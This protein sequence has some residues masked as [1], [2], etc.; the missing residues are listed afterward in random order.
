MKLSIIIVNWNNQDYIQKCL[1]SIHK[2]IT[3]SEYEIIV[4][5]NNS[6]DGSATII[7]ETYPKVIMLQNSVN[8]GFSKANNQGIGIAKGEHVLFLNSDTELIDNSIDKMIEFM[9]S[10][11]KIGTVSGKCLYPDGRIQWSIGKFPSP[12]MFLRSCILDPYIKH[13][14]LKILCSYK[15][16]KITITADA[17]QEQDYP[18][19]A[20]FM[21]KRNILK[22]IEGFDENLFLYAEDMD[23]GYRIQKCGLINYYL[24]S[25]KVMHHASVSSMKKNPQKS[26]IEWLVSHRYFFKKNRGNTRIILDLAITMNII[27]KMCDILLLGAV[28]KKNGSRI[29]GSLQECVHIY[30]SVFQQK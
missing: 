29:Y 28:G 5:D 4:I 24:P 8:R 14:I 20:Y 15:S 12:Y 3:D 11:N 13:T 17:I 23:L 21:I 1:N 9:A 30:K 18:Y 26:H 16:N 25:A 10:N 22:K 2:Y 6:S 7:R 19:G 27:M